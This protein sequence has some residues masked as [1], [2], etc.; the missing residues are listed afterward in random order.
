MPL[1]VCMLFCWEG[2]FY[3]ELIWCRSS[4]YV[5]WHTSCV[6]L[7]LCQNNAICS[8]LLSST[9]Q[10]TVLSG[11][12]STFTYDIALQYGVATHWANS[13]ACNKDFE[14]HI[15]TKIQ[16]DF[17][18]KQ[19]LLQ[20]YPLQL[21]YSLVSV[22]VVFFEGLRLMCSMISLFHFLSIFLFTL[23]SLETFSNPVCG[24]LANSVA[25][26]VEIR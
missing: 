7:F 9:C 13:L 4:I 12:V 11:L 14:P 22:F 5:H 24:K 25:L 20:K 2:F 15:K 23:S 3:L 19:K 8:F 10:S 1:Y 16:E 18:W 17:L 26:K 6:I 21:K